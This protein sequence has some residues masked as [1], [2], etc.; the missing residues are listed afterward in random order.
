MVLILNQENVEKNGEY[1]RSKQGRTEEDEA[2]C[3]KE[4]KDGEAATEADL[5]PRLGEAQSKEDGTRHVQALV[6][7]KN[8]VGLV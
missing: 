3:A 8:C 1:K 5:C 6:N 2:G 4:E 7:G